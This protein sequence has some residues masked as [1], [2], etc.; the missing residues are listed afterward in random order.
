VLIPRLFGAGVVVAAWSPNGIT[1]GPF[2]VACFQK[3]VHRSVTTIPEIRYTDGMPT[4]IQKP[5]LAFLNRPCARGG[6]VRED[7]RRRCGGIAGNC[8]PKCNR[9]RRRCHRLG[10]IS[11]DPIGFAAGDVNQ[12]RYV[13][14]GPTNATDPS[15]LEEKQKTPPDWR[16]YGQYLDWQK[17]EMAYYFANVGAVSR[18]TGR[19]IDEVFLERWRSVASEFQS[20]DM[21]ARQYFDKKLADSPAMDNGPC[22]ASVEEYDR[23]QVAQ[24]LANA[25]PVERWLAY[26]FLPAEVNPHPVNLDS[27]M[28]LLGGLTPNAMPKPLRPEKVN[29][30][31]P[32]APAERPQKIAITRRGIDRVEEHLK[33]FGPDA[34]NQAMI[35]RLRAGKTSSHDINFYVH[36]LKES[37]LMARGVQSRPAHRETLEWQ[38]ILYRPGYENQLYHPSVICRFRENFNEAAWPK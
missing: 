31:R 18:K 38:G 12:Y 10:S 35:G 19:S 7:S 20:R 6:I 9:E 24:S 25:H 26:F 17:E 4:R 1:P 3:T 2:I 22:Y 8:R 34:P 33:R 14:N 13:G 21:Y 36:E 27:S 29:V 32:P 16:Y 37:A 28:I 5:R 15:G 23:Q 30:S 11:K